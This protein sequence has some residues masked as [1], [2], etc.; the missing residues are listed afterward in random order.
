MIFSDLFVAS[1]LQY[2][3]ITEIGTN[4]AQTLLDEVYILQNFEDMFTTGNFE[5][6]FAVEPCAQKQIINFYE[7]GNLT[8]K[9]I[10]CLSFHGL[11]S[12]LS[13]ILTKSDSRYTKSKIYFFK[14]VFYIN[15]FL[16]AGRFYF[17]MLKLFC[18]IDMGIKC[19]GKLG[20]V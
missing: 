1:H 16:Y 13:K 14:Y 3:F 4:Y 11:A 20:A 10:K 2:I 8:S 19:I 18:M 15:S 17:I 12:Q 7:Y 6:R 5:D 9:N